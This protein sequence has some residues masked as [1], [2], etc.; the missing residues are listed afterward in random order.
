MTFTPIVGTL[1]YLWDQERD[2]VLLI[3]RDARPDD[4][5]FGKVNG[6][7]GKVEIDEGDPRVRSHSCPPRAE[8]RTCIDSAFLP[9]R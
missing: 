3:R 8:E 7:G 1:V 5:H 6:L 9:W 4:D 2:Q